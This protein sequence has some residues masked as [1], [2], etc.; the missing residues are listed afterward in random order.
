MPHPPHRRWPTL[1]RLLIGLLATFSLILPEA[2]AHAE[3]ANEKIDRAVV[4][5]LKDGKASY[6]VRLKGEASLATAR[7]AT[8]KAAKAQAVHDAKSAHAN[9]SQAG[10]RRLLTERK[11]EHT[12]FW[13]VNAVKVTAD[14]KLTSEIA[15]LPEVAAIDPIDEI[16]MPEPKPGKAQ[17]RVK[18]KAANAVEWNI[19]R[20]KAP[21]V[22]NE[23]NNRGEGVVVAIIDTWPDF[24]HPAL[25]AQYRGRHADGRVD[26]N[27]NW[28]DPHKECAT[29][30]PCGTEEHGTHVTGTVAGENGI[31][32][33]PGVKWIAA[34]GCARGSCAETSLI[35]AGQWLIEPTDLNGQNVRYDL[36]PDIVNN[37]WKI[38][39]DTSYEH[40]VDSWIAAGIFPMFANGNGGEMGCGSS[41]TPAVYPQSYSS[42]SLN[43][44][45]ELGRG[46]ATGP[47]RDGDIKPNISAPGVDIRSSAPYG[48]YRLMSGTSM[49]SPHVAGAVALMWSAAPS[50]RGDIDATRRLLDDTAIDMPASDCGGTPDDNNVFGEG[51]LDAYAAVRAVPDDALGDLRGTVTAGG[52]PLRDAEVRV[53]ASSGRKVGTA[54]NGGYSMLRLPPGQ[55]EITASK[56]GHRSASRTVT[57]VDGQVATGDFDLLRLPHGTVTGTVTA[58]GAAEPGATVLVP[59]T[60]VKAVTDTSGRYRITLPHGSYRL[61]TSGASHC[62]TTAAHQVTVAGNVTRDVGLDVRRD[63]FGYTCEAGTEPYIAGTDRL[64]FPMQARLPF[65]MP[66]YGKTYSEVWIEPSGVISFA[67]ISDGGHTPLPNPNAPNLALYPYWATLNV[68][69]EAD[70]Y[71]GTVGTAPNRTFVVEWRNVRIDDPEGSTDRLSFSVLLTEDGTIS[72]RYK[73]VDG[74]GDH[75]VG[76][77][78]GIENADGTDAFQY[79]YDSSS[80]KNGQSLTF[81]AGT[82]GTVHGR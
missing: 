82:R 73:D 64:S 46:S 7:T 57:I 34:R 77:T 31:G 70:I 43:I 55:Y 54:A 47:G 10:L 5:D 63:T 4:A 19:D 42:G 37:S 12:P 50:L 72:Y 13:I 29:F 68:D 3:P 25:A 75:G 74:T 22:W 58:G 38:P 1:G 80:I 51:A 23:L 35:A 26:H 65:A 56:F 15:A 76:A 53:T 41:D 52:M 67:T 27:Y 71:T 8:T 40:I 21:Q 39:A 14:A 2:I 44:D 18:G 69:A 16:E 28:F 66:F 48:D 78:I 60:P 32:V 9:K 62:V 6:L 24:D 79:S 20:V 36:V 49:A 59:G 61:E 30:G 81:T 33:A 45:G 17:P 11:A